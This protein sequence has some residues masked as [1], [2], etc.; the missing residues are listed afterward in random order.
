MV[1]NVPVGA[2]DANLVVISE[3]STESGVDLNRQLAQPGSAAA[4][5][6]AQSMNRRG[7]LQRIAVAQSP[8]VKSRGIICAGGFII[9]CAIGRAGITRQKREGDGA[10]PCGRMA[11]VGV[12]YRPDRVRRPVTGLP[13]FPL[14]RD[15]GWC[16]DPTDRRYNR[17][18][19]LPFR[20]SH[21][22]LWRTDNLYDLIVVLDYNLDH[23]RPGAG[24]AIFLHIA[25]ADFAPTEGCV[26]VAMP[27]MRR[28][29]AQAG[30]GT[31]LVTR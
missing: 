1:Y 10:T 12:F 3:E 29:L 31:C 11:L 23:P 5:K 28:L 4:A 14:R 6:Q 21:E 16:D 2:Y 17:A 27:S 24:S 30:P 20:A 25:T 15:A 8:T 19:S 7:W 18:V 26:A 22:R 13:V 9:P